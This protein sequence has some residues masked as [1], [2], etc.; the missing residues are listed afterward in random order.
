MRPQTPGR[1]VEKRQWRTTR[2]WLDPTRIQ[3]DSEG[4]ML[5]MV[6]GSLKSKQKPRGNEGKG[7]YDLTLKV[8]GGGSGNFAIQ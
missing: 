4:S 3:A 6:I 1:L 8:D 7:E 2:H 5:L